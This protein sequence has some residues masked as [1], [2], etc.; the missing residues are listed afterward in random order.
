MATPKLTP[1]AAGSNRSYALLFVKILLVLVIIL[2]LPK[3]VSGR[4]SRKTKKRRLSREFFL[5]QRECLQTGQCSVLIPEEATPCV[6][7]CISKSCSDEIYSANPLELGEVDT[8]REREFVAC[9]KK[10]IRF[11]TR[12]RKSSRTTRQA[13][14]D[15]ISESL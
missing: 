8:M 12:D 1:S 5:K 13:T 4:S 2:M 10:E 14:V 15:S 9:T 7:E 11:E 3:L 6:A